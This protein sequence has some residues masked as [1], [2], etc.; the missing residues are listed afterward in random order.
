[1]RAYCGK[2]D[3]PKFEEKDGPAQLPKSCYYTGMD[4][5]PSPGKQIRVGANSDLLLRW[6]RQSVETRSC[7]PQA[8]GSRSKI[9]RRR[10]ATISTTSR[11]ELTRPIRNCSGRNP[12]FP[13]WPELRACRAGPLSPDHPA[14][15]PSYGDPGRQ[16]GPGHIGDHYRFI[17]VEWIS[18]PGFVMAAWFHRGARPRNFRPQLAPSCGRRGGGQGDWDDS[19]TRF[20]AVINSYLTGSIV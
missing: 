14:D 15:Q 4:G 3:V 7:S 6:S 20:I 16:S 2:S 12:H 10:N 13:G 8:P 1:M 11:F 5:T 9:C 19:G 17:G 18:E